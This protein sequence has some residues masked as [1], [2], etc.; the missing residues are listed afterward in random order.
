MASQDGDD[1]AGE[2]VGRW[3]RP[4]DSRPDARA[5]AKQSEAAQTDGIQTIQAL[6]GNSRAGLARGV[7][8]AGTRLDAGPPGKRGPGRRRLWL[9]VLFIDMLVLAGLVAAGMRTWV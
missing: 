4:D 3:V 9:W 6:L 5:L 1:F 7:R 2:H 8:C